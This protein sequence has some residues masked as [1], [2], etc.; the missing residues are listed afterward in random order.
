MLQGFQGLGTLF[1][2]T[3]SMVKLDG[4]LLRNIAILS[5]LAV[6]I[7]LATRI[8]LY[9]ASL[10]IMLTGN[11]NEIIQQFN[12]A[13]QQIFET[14]SKP[15]QDKQ[16]QTKDSPTDQIQPQNSIPPPLNQVPSINQHSRGIQWKRSQNEPKQSNLAIINNKSSQANI[17][18]NSLGSSSATKKVL[19]TRQSDKINNKNMR[20]QQNNLQTSSISANSQDNSKVIQDNNKVINK[21]INTSNSYKDSNGVNLGNG[22]TYGGQS[23]NSGFQHDKNSIKGNKDQMFEIDSKNDEFERQTQDPWRVPRTKVL[24]TDNGIK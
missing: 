22:S 1:R 21:N 5:T 19:W 7:F 2:Q 11:L 6:A 18:E 20:P 9:L 10:Q 3:A 13:K 4:V 17:E 12:K 24:Q 15:E 23:Q 14:N 16:N 8:R